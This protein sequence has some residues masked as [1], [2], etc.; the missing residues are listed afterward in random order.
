MAGRP[1]SVGT[2]RHLSLSE[3]AQSDLALLTE[4]FDAAGPSEVLRHALMH[5]R[6]AQ[7]LR[8]ANL[9]LVALDRDGHQTDL[10]AVPEVEPS[11]A[12]EA[13][14]HVTFSETADANLLAA[15]KV[16][17]TSVMSTVAEQALLH[18]GLMVR[19]T[20]RGERAV[21]MEG[22]REIASYTIWLN[23]TSVLRNRKKLVETV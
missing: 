22:D 13:K 15:A 18:Y 6:N 2:R 10:L 9:R 14:M 8:A 5:L 1:P 7:R 23:I 12:R 19:R 4:T 11:A 17:G 16:L 3:P 21:V 20:Q